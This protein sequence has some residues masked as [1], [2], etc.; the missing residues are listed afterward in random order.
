MQMMGLPGLNRTNLVLSRAAAQPVQKTQYRAGQRIVSSPIFH[1][2][3][4]IRCEA[5]VPKNPLSRGRPWSGVVGFLT[6]PP[7]YIASSYRNFRKNDTR[8]RFLIK[9]HRPFTALYVPS[10][11]CTRESPAKAAIRKIIRFD[12]KNDSTVYSYPCRESLP[13]APSLRPNAEGGHSINRRSKG[14]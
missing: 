9:I 1:S 11:S 4:L 3:F 14:R 7:H 12:G 10:Y 13:A 2:P 6:P 8:E 5:Y